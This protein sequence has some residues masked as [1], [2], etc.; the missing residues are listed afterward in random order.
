MWYL[1]EKQDEQLLSIKHFP[2]HREQSKT[3]VLVEITLQQKRCRMNTS[4]WGVFIS[5][6]DLWGACEQCTTLYRASMTLKLDSEGWA[7]RAKISG[8]WRGNGLGVLEKASWL[9]HSEEGTK[10]SWTQF[11]GSLPVMIRIRSLLKFEYEVSHS[12]HAWT[13]GSGYWC[14]FGKPQILKEAKPH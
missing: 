1:I 9:P 4:T 12:S 6:K 13:F 7:G 3:V 5:V 8:P 14:C 10:G 2:R 11:Y